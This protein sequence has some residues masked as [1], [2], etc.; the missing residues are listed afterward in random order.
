[1]DRYIDFNTYEDKL[2]GCWWGKVAGGTLG[3]PF[4]GR[5]AVL[6]VPFYVQENPAGIPNDDVDFQLVSLLACETYHN[7]VDARILAEYWMSLVAVSISEYGVAMNNLRCHLLPPL[8]G[9]VNNP[10]QN[11][12][13]AFIRSEIWACLCAG[14]PDIAV[15]YALEDAS[16]DHFG[17]GVYG[18]IFCAAMEAYAFIES[19]INKIIDKALSFIPENSDLVKAIAVVRECYNSGMSWQ[20]ARYELLS[21]VPGSFGISYSNVAT[22]RDLDLPKCEP[23]YDAPNNISL[24]ILGLLYGVGDFEISLVITNPGGADTDCTAGFA[25]AVIGTILGYLHLPDKWIKPLGSKLVTCCLCFRDDAKY[26]KTIEEL[27]ERILRLTPLFLGS[28]VDIL[29]KGEGYK[30][31]ILSECELLAVWALRHKGNPN[32]RQLP[33]KLIPDFKPMLERV[34]KTAGVRHQDILFDTTVF[35]PDGCEI[36]LGE[37]I[38]L[39]FEFWNGIYEQQQLKCRWLLPEGISITSGNFH[40]IFLDQVHGGFNDAKISF[41]VACNEIKQDEITIVL[42]ITS[43]GRATKT[44]IPVTLHIK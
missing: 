2:K 38:Q 4:E 19:D 39:D 35:Y 24:A 26:P 31:K 12:N 6:D 40:S 13:G 22:G 1:M 37:K 41:E 17:E 42:E 16:V 36:G 33:I 27:C 21:K 20:D 34:S 7:K 18:E 44:Y 14:N 3:A 25:G 11:S 28:S 5:R 23:Y 8:S 43:L 10:C 32:L 29:T 30:I 15:R 9:K